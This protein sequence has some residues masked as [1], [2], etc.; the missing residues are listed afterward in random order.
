MFKVVYSN[1]YGGFGLSNKAVL[2]LHEKYG[3]EY[4]S[5]PHLGKYLKEELE[6]HDPRLVEV[7]EALGKEANGRHSNLAIATIKGRL[8]RIDEYDGLETVVVPNIHEWT[9]IPEDE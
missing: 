5:Y 8:Y 6:R 9:V 3:L 2:W 1:R 7:V 4:E